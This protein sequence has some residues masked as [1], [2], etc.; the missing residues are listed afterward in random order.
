MAPSGQGR[1]LGLL[2]YGESWRRKADLLTLMVDGS[3]SLTFSLSGKNI[4]WRQGRKIE[5]W[6]WLFQA[7]VKLAN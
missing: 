2:E 6:L 4:T 1:S 3:R 7:S 5:Q